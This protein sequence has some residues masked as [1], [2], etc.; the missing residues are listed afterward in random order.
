M[1]VTHPLAKVA[2]IL[3]G[4]LATDVKMCAVRAEEADEEK[5]A[6]PEAEGERGAEDEKERSTVES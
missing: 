2:K 1:G 3:A 5:A 4:S 6:I